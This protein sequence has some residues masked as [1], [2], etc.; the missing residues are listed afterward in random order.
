MSLQLGFIGEKQACEYLC[1]Q[2]LTW[3][4]SNYRCRMGEIDLIMRDRDYLVFVEVR[5][6]KHRSYG[7]GIQSITQSKRQKLLRT[8]SLY[9]QSKKLNEKQPCRFDMLSLDGAL[10]EITWIKNAFGVDF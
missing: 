1:Q 9:L 2:G 7:G 10:S 3:V 6:R 5:L 8:A 4:E